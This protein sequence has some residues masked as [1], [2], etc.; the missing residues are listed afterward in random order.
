MFADKTLDA[1]VAGFFPG[2]LG[3]AVANSVRLMLLNLSKAI[4]IPTK[5]SILALFQLNIGLR[6]FES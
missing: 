1:S 4:N 3:N 2:S 5:Q 6:T